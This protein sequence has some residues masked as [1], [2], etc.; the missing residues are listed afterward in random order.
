MFTEDCQTHPFQ[1]L[2]TSLCILNQTVTSKVDLLSRRFYL[3]YLDLP[4][5]A[6]HLNSQL[7]QCKVMKKMKT[8]TETPNE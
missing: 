1:R 2:S 5:V 4:F 6:K 3:A 8:T 7:T